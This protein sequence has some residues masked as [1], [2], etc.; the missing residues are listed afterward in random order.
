MLTGYQLA[1]NGRANT[2]CYKGAA[3]T[4]SG[5]EVTPIPCAPNGMLVSMDWALPCSDN[6]V[7]VTDFEYLRATDN[8]KPRADAQ[9]VLTVQNSANGGTYGRWIVPDTYTAATWV[10][11]CCAGCDPLPSVTI[12]APIIFYAEC[13]LAAPTVPGCVYKGATFIPALTGGNTTFTATAYGFAADGTAIV[14]SPTTSTGTTVA[15]LAANMQTNWASE[16]GTGTFT[17]TGNTI[18]YT[19]TN[20]ARVG[21]TVVQS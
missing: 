13:T 14:F 12:P 4:A 8:T 3:D 18:N 10:T 9:K 7:T 21:F 5:L 11:A 19:S 2:A 17:A 6:G 1:Y 16:L 15:L 20:G